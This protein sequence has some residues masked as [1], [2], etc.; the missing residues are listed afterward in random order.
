V[1]AVQD[2]RRIQPVRH[3]TPLAPNRAMKT[4]ANSL[5]HTATISTCLVL[6]WAGCA[7]STPGPTVPTAT[8]SADLPSNHEVATS[9]APATTTP[10]PSP[11]LEASSA[12]SALS[13]SQ[14]PRPTDV[15]LDDGQIAMIASAIDRAEIAAAKL[16]L[17]HAK[18]PRVRQFAQHMV[19]VH[20]A[21]EQKL[22]I[23]LKAENVTP[24]DSA[25]STKLVSDSQAAALTLSGQSGSD[26][27]SSYIAAQ[28]QAHQDVLAMMDNKLIP[29]AKD[30][31][32]KAALEGTRVKV[33]EHIAMAR[34]VQAS[35]ASP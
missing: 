11:T 32:L 8:T 22:N 17:T 23:T 30:A 15:A 21:V 7:S 35:L 31:K 13:G 29:S 10:T 1:L 3:G 33:V 18:S 27:D 19:S 6:G 16:A 24:S 5:L 26:F 20:T 12:N 4:L 14:T 25:M 34:D 2:T 28:L 9:Y